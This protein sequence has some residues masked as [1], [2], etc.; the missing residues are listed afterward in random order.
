MN[1]VKTRN[2]DWMKVRVYFSITRK[3]WIVAH[4]CIILRHSHCFR[5]ALPTV[6]DY[7]KEQQKPPLQKNF[8]RFEPWPPKNPVCR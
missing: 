4:G 1:R 2:G 5:D 8:S 7:L 6:N 3:R